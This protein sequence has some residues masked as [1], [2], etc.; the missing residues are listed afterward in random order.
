LKNSSA[1]AVKVGQGG[2]CVS[3]EHQVLVANVYNHLSV[4]HSCCLRCWSF[5]VCTQQLFIRNQS[6]DDC[7]P[8]SCSDA[9]NTSCQLDR[10]CVTRWQC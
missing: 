8:A 4:S 5:A 3:Q 6:L 7:R 2:L 9:F 10:K 1:T